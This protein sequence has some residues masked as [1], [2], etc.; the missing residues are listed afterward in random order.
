[1]SRGFGFRGPINTG[2]GLLE[3]AP[4]F[5]NTDQGSVHN[6]MKYKLQGVGDLH[7]RVPVDNRMMHNDGVNLQPRMSLAK[8]STGGGWQEQP[9]KNRAMRDRSNLDGQVH[10]DSRERQYYSGGMQK[11]YINED[12]Y[13]GCQDMGMF[14]EEVD[15]RVEGYGEPARS[16]MGLLKPC[17]QNGGLI[18][19][20]KEVNYD[21]FWS[22]SSQVNRH[23]YI[24][25]PAVHVGLIEQTRG[26]LL[27]QP[28]QWQGRRHNERWGMIDPVAHEFM[29]QL[30]AKSLMDAPEQGALLDRSNICSDVMAKAEL[31]TRMNRPFCMIENAESHMVID[32]PRARGLLEQSNRHAYLRK[33]AK[34][35][36]RM[37]TP[38]QRES[39]SRTNRSDTNQTAELHMKIIHQE[40][41]Q[42]L[43]RIQPLHH[44]QAVIMHQ[45]HP[46]QQNELL[47]SGPGLAGKSEVISSIFDMQHKSVL[48]KRPGNSKITLDNKQS[49]LR[50]DS[51]RSIP[52]QCEPHDQTKKQTSRRK[53]HS[54]QWGQ[55]HQK[56]HVPKTYDRKKSGSPRH[57]SHHVMSLNK[58]SKEEKSEVRDSRDSGHQ[59]MT[60]TEVTITMRGEAVKPAVDTMDKV[61]VEKAKVDIDKEQPLTEEK[62][63]EQSVMEEQVNEEQV[64]EEQVKEKTLNEVK[65]TEAKLEQKTDKDD[66]KKNTKEMSLTVTIDKKGRSVND[67]EMKS[68]DNSSENSTSNYKCNVCDVVCFDEMSFSRHMNGLKHH[69]IMDAIM[70]NTFKQTDII[71][72]RLQA[73]KHLHQIQRP[74]KGLASKVGPFGKGLESH[75]SVCNKNFIGGYTD[76]MQDKGHKIYEERCKAGCKLCN[77]SSFSTYLDYTKHLHSIWHK[78]KMKR[79][80]WPRCNLCNQKFKSPRKFVRHCKT[81]HHIK[82][83]KLNKAEDDTEA[84]ELGEL[85]TLDTIGFE[86]DSSQSEQDIDNNL[87]YQKHMSADDTPSTSTPTI[88]SMPLNELV[89]PVRPMQENLPGDY[90]PSAAVGLTYIVPL[91][92]FFCKLCHKFYHNESSAR[93]LHCQSV[94]HFEQYQKTLVAEAN[95]K[96]QVGETVSANVSITAQAAININHSSEMN[97]YLE[98]PASLDINMDETADE[99]TDN[100]SEVSL[101]GTL[102]DQ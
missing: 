70:V 88:S 18:D 9:S 40:K 89:T 69:K 85:V 29:D 101:N 12:E 74:S 79:D 75:C 31:Q 35:E 26:D 7:G 58:D 24:H 96:C 66:E 45:Q 92:G 14:G 22:S 54:G 11:E 99:D 77:V 90:D 63:R 47:G 52:S 100:N 60:A 41:Q 68:E 56:F 39:L 20:R 95:N 51:R 97:E 28:V 13:G 3:E 5:Q 78:K 42:K 102:G 8:P 48:G 67:S 15:G 57:S 83:K 93:V 55:S 80:L 10:P 59:S 62:V 53:A 82:N 49:R 94:S 19:E 30:V 23:K 98:Q 6:G 44:Q 86:D 34:L 61:L 72:A 2:N 27:D 91:T 81:S 32:Q 38:V 1:M 25:E 71:K 84:D 37:N 16:R 50:A 33:N 73:E 4:V 76:H 65:D 36:M 17:D 87:E 46:Q 43:E 21:Q 64:K